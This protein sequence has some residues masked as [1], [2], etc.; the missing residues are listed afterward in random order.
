MTCPL[1][2]ITQRGCE[3]LMER[4]HSNISLTMAD[5]TFKTQHEAESEVGKVTQM[6]MDEVSLIYS[7]NCMSLAA[8][9][10]SVRLC[11][12]KPYGCLWHA[13]SWRCENKQRLMAISVKP[14][15][16]ASALFVI[17]LFSP[18][19]NQPGPHSCSLRPRPLT[20]WQGRDGEWSG[21]AAYWNQL[22]EGSR[23]NQRA[24]VSRFI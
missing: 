14:F 18:N 16:R 19:V 24:T 5:D 12:G 17:S 10:F 21:G 6:L 15:L 2:F 11:T 3:P 4:C 22:T 9:I 8:S 13:G 20:F 1:C 23:C 7:N